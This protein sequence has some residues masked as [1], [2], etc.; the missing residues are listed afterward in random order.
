MS[1]DTNKKSNI[2]LDPRHI[3]VNKTDPGIS[4]TRLSGV[5]G[6]RLT[7]RFYKDEQGQIQKESQPLFSKGKAET[8]TLKK[9]SDIEGIVNSLNSHQAIATGTFDKSSC[10]IVTKNNFS[11]SQYESGTRT[12][13][14]EHMSQPEH[15]LVLLDYDSDPH[16]PEH[17]KCKSLVEAMTK[18]F[19]A[20][21]E[22][23]GVGYS[24][25]GS[26]S[27]GIEDEKTGAPY[28]GGGGMHIYITV[29]GVELDQLQQYLK[30]RLWNAGMGFISF[31]RNG[32]MLKRTLIDLSVLS[33]ERLIYEAKPVLG[34][35][36]GQKE[37]V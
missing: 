33:P 11:D 12:R 2:V 26:S 14:K 13:S 4:L 18:L 34:E 19:S 29:K 28:S 7:K 22:L 25:I 1:F 30:V 6:T 15:G 27:N 3:T 24:A 8:L 35:G 10:P 36:V 16:M 37:C 31:A 9:L 20:V 21:P 5:Q 17:M 32:A 23:A